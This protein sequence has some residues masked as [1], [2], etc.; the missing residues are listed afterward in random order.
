MRVEKA[1]FPVVLMARLLGVSRAGFYAWLNRPLSAREKEDQVLALEIRS[2]H[3]IS[4]GTYGSPRVRDELQAKGY[5]VGRRRVSRLMRG[6]GL[7]GIPRRRSR[8]NPTEEQDS[9]SISNVLDRAFQVAEPNRVWA[10]DITYLW[11]KNGW[12]YLAVVIDLASRRVV[13]WELSEHPDSDL[14]LAALNQAL[15]QRGWKPGLLLHHDQGCQY[16]SKALGR[17]RA[18]RGL[19]ASMSRRG[20]CWDNAVVESFFATLKKELV[21]RTFWSNSAEA[22]EEI[23]EYI[24]VFYNRV[25]RHSTI[26]SVSPRDYELAIAS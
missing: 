22:R 6:E 24:E 13:G 23:F 25:R 3:R 9:T 18:K 11:T 17:L 15:D 19:V 12:C 4:R 8:R 10:S 26:G 16:T 5:E 7:R 14:V 20:N 2:I 21:Y 1:N